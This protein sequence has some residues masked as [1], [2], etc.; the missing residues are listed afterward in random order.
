M[1]DTTDTQNAQQ[2]NF[3]AIPLEDFQGA[4]TFINQALPTGLGMPL[5]ERLGRN[6]GLR[7]PPENLPPNFYPSQVEA[8]AGDGAQAHRAVAV[9]GPATTAGP[10]V[11]AASAEKAFL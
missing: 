7:I 10:L 9:A 6:I 5:L 4:L 11:L 3:V 2:P 1:S 8:P